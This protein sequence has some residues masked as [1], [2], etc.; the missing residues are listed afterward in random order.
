M[1]LLMS[2]SRS[3]CSFAA[4]PCLADSAKMRVGATPSA[5][6]ADFTCRS[7]SASTSPS[8]LAPSR[9]PSILLSATKQVASMPP[10]GATCSVQSA[11]SAGV[12]PRSAESMKTIAAASGTRWNESSGSQASVV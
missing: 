2:P 12:M 6:A 11:R 8:P 4:S 5:S 3:P 9:S 10:M 1:R 7:I